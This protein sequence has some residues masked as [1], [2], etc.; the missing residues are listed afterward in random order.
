MTDDE[1]IKIVPA[2]QGWFVVGPLNDGL[3][4][5]TWK[6]PVVAWAVNVARK[7]SQRVDFYLAN[8]V[9]LESILGDEFA[10]LAPDG[11]VHEVESTVHEN[12][13]E[14]VKSIVRTRE[15][16]FGVTP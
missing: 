6:T 9:I 5:A 2:S 7:E 15:R 4:E 8:P 13:D 12:V 1:L 3:P 11:Q 16:L 14:Y 10:F